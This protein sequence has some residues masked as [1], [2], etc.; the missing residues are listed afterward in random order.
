MLAKA[1][2]VIVPSRWYENYPYSVLEAFALGKPVIAANIGGLPE[3]VSQATGHLFT[4]NDPVSLAAAVDAVMA[5]DRVQLGKAARH[6]VE[7]INS[8]Q[9]HY[10]QLYTLY[11]QLIATT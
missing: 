9:Q 7:T 11:E 10:T 8:P 4:P 3:M 5:A 1:A 6:N 2:A